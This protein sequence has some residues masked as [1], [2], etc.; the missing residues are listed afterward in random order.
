[1]NKHQFAILIPT[2][3]HGGQ[4]V[5][6]VTEALKLNYPVIVVDDGSTDD[7]Y[8]KLKHIN[9]IHLIRHSLNQGKGAAFTT[10]FAKAVEFADWVITIDSDG[11]HSVEDVVRLVQSIP[12]NKRP[13]MI[14]MRVMPSHVPW[15]SRFGRKF[16]NFWVWVS[17]GPKL[18]DSQSGFR[19]YPIPEAIHLEVQAKRYQFEVE[20]L[21]KANRQ[22]IPVIEIPVRVNYPEQRISHFRPLMDFIRN[23]QTFYDL[24]IQRMFR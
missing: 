5:N 2:Y 19:I 4:V 15:T 18:S 23:S 20:V 22:H 16:S 6:V 14:G 12:E 7:T 17:G 13:I 10:G 21:V 11:Q 24:I 1:M 8:E 3:N 9:T